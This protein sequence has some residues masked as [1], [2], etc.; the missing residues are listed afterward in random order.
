[1]PAWIY[2]GWS[3]A[4]P[5]RAWR[6]SCEPCESAASAQCSS[7]T[8]RGTIRRWVS[9]CSE[10]RSRRG[11]RRV[12]RASTSRRLRPRGAVMVGRARST[13]CCGGDSPPRRSAVILLHPLLVLLAADAERGFGTGFEPLDRNLFAA[14]FADAERAFVDLAQRLLDFVEKALLSPSQAE[15]KRLQIFARS[16]IHFVGQVVRIERH[17]L[18]ERLLGLLE[19]LVALVGQER[20]EFLEGRLVHS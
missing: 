18:L 3:P 2:T 14:L 13:F 5:M 7:S 19:N 6:F 10:A 20:S 15:G 8:G 9:G 11:C 17:V 1:M 4:T 12:P 16:Q